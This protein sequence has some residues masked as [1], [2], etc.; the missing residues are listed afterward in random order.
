[1]APKKNPHGKDD[2]IVAK[3]ETL[4]KVVVKVTI[5]AAETDQPWHKAKA[6]SVIP[7]KRRLIKSLMMK[8]IFKICCVTV[9]LLAKPPMAGV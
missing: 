9:L 1:M 4:E 3:P 7:K 6:G 5:P 2:N 8:N